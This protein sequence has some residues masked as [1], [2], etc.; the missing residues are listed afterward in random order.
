MISIAKD[1]KKGQLLFLQDTHPTIVG[2]EAGYG[3][4]G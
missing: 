1:Y 3:V 4:R 2:G